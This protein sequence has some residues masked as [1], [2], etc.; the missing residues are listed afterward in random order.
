MNWREYDNQS[1]E[2]GVIQTLR[3]RETII[4]TLWLSVGQKLVAIRGYLWFNL[5]N[6]TKTPTGI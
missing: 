4:K 5:N 6:T 3:T 1:P 2:K